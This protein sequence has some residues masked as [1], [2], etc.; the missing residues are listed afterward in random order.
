MKVWKN[1]SAVALVTWMVGA[2]PAQAQQQ[3]PI[4]PVRIVVPYAAG[5]VTDVVARLVGEELVK[6]LGQP[7]VV[8]NR[9][10]AGGSIGLE[11]VLR[12]PHDGYMI[13]MMPA[14]I[15]VMKALYPKLTFDP[16]RDFTPIVMLGTTPSGISAHVS[17]PL[18]SLKE[19]VAY[20]KANPGKL[21]Y[22]AC[23]IASPQHLT[24]E[25]LKALAGINIVHV[26]YRGCAEANPDVLTGRVQIYSATIPHLLL[27]Q[28]SGKINILAMTSKVRT[29]WTPQVPTVVEAGYPDLAFEA[30]FGFLAPRDTPKEVVA[31]INGEV[32]K[33]LM[34]PEIQKKMKQ[35]YFAPVGGSPESFGA[36]INSDAK[37]L[38]AVVTQAG[39]KVE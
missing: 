8:E 13:A 1:L 30:W 15:T 34:K 6:P 32:N 9:T 37:L 3:Y 33:I 7:V 35:L 39:I 18:K 26:P 19:M 28:Q 16:I 22:A 4:K 23:G 20:A 2:Y 12:A 21:N 38:G 24:A 25:Y 10:G 17:L 31:R 14:N 11:S 29:E 27:G 5:G 36:I